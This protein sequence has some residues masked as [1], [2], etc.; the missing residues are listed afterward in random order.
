MAKKIKWLRRELLCGPYL[1]LVRDEA[2]WKAAFK[3]LGRCDEHFPKSSGQCVT[4]TNASGQLCAIV[5]IQ[6]TEDKTPIEIAGL[7]VH[8]A[9]HVVQGY[10][11][12]IGE[13]EIG[14][15]TEAYA[16][17]IVAQRLMAA[18]CGEDHA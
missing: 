10:L 1:C 5:L 16:I 9:V 4:L 18:W 11:A 2:E 17:Q 7:I 8:E 6:N 13:S 3:Q 12:H 14:Q 15:E